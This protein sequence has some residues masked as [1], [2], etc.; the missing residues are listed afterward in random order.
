MSGRGQAG[1]RVASAPSPPD[2]FSVAA[3]PFP[4]LDRLVG[5]ERFDARSAGLEPA[6]F[7]WRWATRSPVIL[8]S[9]Q[10]RLLRGERTDQTFARSVMR[11][12]HAVSLTS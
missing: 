5:K 4:L 7:S 12:S 3:H 6:V 11:G 8:S 2:F 10:A 1:L 9:S